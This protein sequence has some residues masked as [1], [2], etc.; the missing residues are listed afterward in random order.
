VIQDGQVG[1]AIL[2]EIAN[3][4]AT[5]IHPSG[6]RSKRLKLTVG[7]P[8]EHVDRREVAFRYVEY[9]IAVKIGNRYA[10]RMG[11]RGIIHIVLKGTVPFAEYDADVV[12]E[13]SDYEVKLAIAIKIPGTGGGRSACEGGVF[14]DAEGAVA[15]AGKKADPLAC[16]HDIYLAVPVEIT[17]DGSVGK[18]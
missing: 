2:I 5:R 15:V 6:I 11:A 18:G 14:S 12:A 9:A 7:V 10:V 16:L 13:I 8:D 3:Y 1:F 4:N 17:S